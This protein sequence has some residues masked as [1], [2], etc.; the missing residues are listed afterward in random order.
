MARNAAF[1]ADARAVLKSWKAPE[2]VELLIAV[3]LS[4]GLVQAIVSTSP[5]PDG[6]AA[7]VTWTLG[8]GT[9]LAPAMVRSFL[10]ILAEEVLSECARRAAGPRRSVA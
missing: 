6:H 10:G 4:A 9:D 3:D 1:I 2:G 7:E 5:R 8:Q